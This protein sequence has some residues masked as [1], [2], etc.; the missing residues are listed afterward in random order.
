MALL[1]VGFQGVGAWLGSHSGCC[2]DPYSIFQ[3]S[4][5]RALGGVAGS[6][7]LI[8]DHC[9]SHYFSESTATPGPPLLVPTLGACLL[10]WLTPTTR[11][12]RGMLSWKGLV[13]LGLISYS[14]YLWHQPV[15][16]FGRIIISEPLGFEWRI[17]LLLSTFPLAILSW[18]YIEKP[19]R[20]VGQISTRRLILLVFTMMMITTGSAVALHYFGS[21]GQKTSAGVVGDIGHDRYYEV[22][23]ERFDRCEAEYLQYRI[24]LWENVPRCHQSRR[25]EL[26][27]VA[28]YG[29]SHAEQLFLGAE[30]LLDQASIY[31]IRGGIP[32]LGNDRFKGPLR[33]LEEQKDINVVVFSA[34]WLEKIQILGGEQF[35]AQLFSTV[36]WMVG[37][38]FK[39][40][41]MMDAPDFGFDPALCVYENKLKNARCEITREQHEGDQA[42]YLEF[43]TAI[44]EHPN[45]EVVD[46]SE[47]I[48]GQATCSMLSEGRLLYR[49]NDHLKSPRLPAC[50]RA[51]GPEV[52]VSVTITLPVTPFF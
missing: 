16:V 28:F 6:V 35:S 15:L 46:V 49:D 2:T 34:Y 22:M 45:V 51:V 8:G 27:S 38:G 42:V 9:A 18:Y 37:Q 11:Y 24:E 17:A 3:G 26:P 33:Y 19:F 14:L 31:L 20:H 32:F 21:M 47:A 41:L 44:A 4:G 50:G 5:H 1:Y 52:K 39:V 48:C 23:E 12:L 10:I 25:V 30:A 29:D 40:V 7:R 13:G 36:K 43:F